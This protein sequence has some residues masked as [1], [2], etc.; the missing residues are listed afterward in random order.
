MTVASAEFGFEYTEQ[1]APKMPM[2]DDDDDDHP[3]EAH[4]R[5]TPTP[6]PAPSQPHRSR[7]LFSI[8]TP[9]KRLFDR[10]PLRTYPSSGRPIRSPRQRDL[11][12]LYVFCNPQDEW[13]GRPSFNPACLK[14]Q[15][16]TGLD[17]Q[18]DHIGS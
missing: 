2:A 14:W 6:A 17:A 18:M 12:A 3:G 13:Q 9:L 16:R 11:V 15:V 7:D 1:W 10:F 8:P 4:V 5:A